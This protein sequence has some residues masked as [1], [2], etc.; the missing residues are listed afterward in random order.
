MSKEQGDYVINYEIGSITFVNRIIPPTSTILVS[1]E[2][3]N[4]NSSAGTVQGAGVSL[5]LSKFGRVGLTMIEQ[6][7][8]SGG[9]LSSRVEQFEGFGAAGTPYFLEF[10]PLSTAQYPTIIRVNGVLQ[11]NGVDYYFDANNKSIFYF[12]RF[13]PSSNI[14]EVS[15]FPRPTSVA[16]GDRRVTGFDYRLPF[17]KGSYLQYSQA[18]G[19]LRSDVTP[20]KGTAKGLSAVYKAGPLELKAGW[21][22]VPNTF[23]GIES[24]GF[25]RNEKAIDFSAEFAKGGFTH[26]VAHQNSAVSTRTVDQ[27]GNVS[28]NNGRQTTSRLYS[29]YS[30]DSW[31]WN[32][33]QARRTVTSA[34][35]DTKLDTTSFFGS[36]KW[37]K[38]DARFGL[39]HQSGVAP[40]GTGKSARLSL[41]SLRLDA[42]YRPTKELSL[43]WRSSLSKVKYGPDSGTGRDMGV[44]ATYRPDE[45]WLLPFRPG[46][47]RGIHWI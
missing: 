44:R 47:V 11:I 28:V 27:S 36:K 14:V 38:V 25:N 37:G 31:M 13:I 6:K 30:S 4:F 46:W 23:V 5:D 39:D 18:I 7:S 10:E 21:R 16:N 9:G 22:D 8:R 34:R 1:Y 3:L 15:Y 17:G 41:D 19:E 29:S 45:K 24:R 40:D 2:S 20:T 43:G 12:R 26:G 35:G 33:E 32:A 42:D